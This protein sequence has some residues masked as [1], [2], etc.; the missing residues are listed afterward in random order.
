MLRDANEKKKN[1]ITLV[2]I[3]SFLATVYSMW[4][5]TL[6]SAYFHIKYSLNC[7]LIGIF[8]I[9]GFLNKFFNLL[10]CQKYFY[11]AF[12]PPKHAFFQGITLA[13][14]KNIYFYNNFLKAYV[15]CWVAT[16]FLTQN[17]AERLE[18]ENQLKALIMLGSKH[19][20]ILYWLCWHTQLAWK[21]LW[22]D[23]HIVSNSI[24]Y[25]N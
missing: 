20:A 13:L 25:S 23:I 24:C 1:L 3:K 9:Q 6:T 2:L 4:E 7:L 16:D 14:W 21:I 10:F 15:C 17:S 11:S 22:L 12:F 8:M 5:V 19:I 18:L